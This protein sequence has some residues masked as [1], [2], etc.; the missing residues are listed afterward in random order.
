MLALS[1][2]NCNLFCRL[3][4]YFFR[5]S[6]I[7][8]NSVAVVKVANGR[9]TTDT[10]DTG[11]EGTRDW[12]HVTIRTIDADGKPVFDTVTSTLGHKYF[13]PFNKKSRNPNTKLEH[14][15]YAE[16]GVKWVSAEDLKKGDKVLLAEA[17]SLTGK[18]RYGIVDKVKCERFDEAQTTYNLEVEDFHTYYV[19]QVGVCVH[20]AG[21]CG[22]NL[23]L[24]NKGST[25]RTEANNL[26]EQLA[27]KQVQSNPLVGAEKLPLKLG[28][29]RWLHS[30]GW[31]K[32]QVTVTSNLT[33]TTVHYVYNP[34]L[35][36]VDDFKFHYFSWLF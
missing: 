15:S 9:A 12:C 5:L 23:Q 29:T 17:D 14:E 20:N 18:P 6:K 10:A 36:L 19:G 3:I 1:P 7:S 13:L 16:L 11:G 4:S 26:Y 22:G 35:G 28:D 24:A 8:P 32:M 31:F 21:P 25:G 33:Q 2:K 34:M 30:D 27:M